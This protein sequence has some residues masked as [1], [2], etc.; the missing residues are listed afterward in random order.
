MYTNV[1]LRPAR[2]PGRG[3]RRIRLV[4][5]A[6]WRIGMVRRTSSFRREFMFARTLLAAIAI[7][8]AACGSARAVAV[9]PF[10]NFEDNTTDGFGALTN[11][12]IQ[13]WAPPVADA[14]ATPALRALE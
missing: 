14:A 10:G 4:T 2:R 13:P 5:S 6:V 8:A 12:G 9:V 1:Y 3:G 7:V 11:S